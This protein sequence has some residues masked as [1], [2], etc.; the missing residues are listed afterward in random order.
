M[1]LE[2]PI[3]GGY[4]GDGVLIDEYV[5]LDFQQNREIIEGFDMTLH[6]FS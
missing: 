4:M 2:T 5:P 1:Q 3:N 6:F